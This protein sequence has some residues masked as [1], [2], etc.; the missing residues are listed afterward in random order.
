[1]EDKCDDY[2][3]DCGDS[4]CDADQYCDKWFK[5]PNL[6]VTSFDN[7]LLSK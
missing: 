6:G 5:N 2:E 7:I 4:G 1:M 3:V